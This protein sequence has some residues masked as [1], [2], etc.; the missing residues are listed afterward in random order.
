MKM[1]VGY[2]PMHGPFGIGYGWILQ[3]AVFIMFFLVVL[4]LIRG[5]RSDQSPSEVLKSRL[6]R[7][8]IT[9]Q[10]YHRLKKEIE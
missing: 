9:K 7:G 4:W 8:E 5:Q 6:A 1:A 2:C 10:E 3:I